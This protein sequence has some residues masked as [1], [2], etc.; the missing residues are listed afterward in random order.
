MRRDAM[1]ATS[2]RTDCA[3]CA[4]CTSYTTQQ[5]SPPPPPPPPLL[6]LITQRNTPR[7]TFSVLFRTA[8]GLCRTTSVYCTSCLA[9]EAGEARAHRTLRNQRVCLS[10]APGNVSHFY[11]SLG[12]FTDKPL[13]DCSPPLPAVHFQTKKEGPNKG[14]WCRTP[15]SPVTARITRP[16]QDFSLH[17]PE[18]QGRCQPLQVL[19]LGY[20]CEASRGKCPA[21]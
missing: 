1:P 11:S 8:S 17:L 6:A 18:A 5:P 4:D 3:D 21:E 9:F 12:L 16:D 14:R 7:R 15:H 13:G 20:G 2:A 10:T 19:S